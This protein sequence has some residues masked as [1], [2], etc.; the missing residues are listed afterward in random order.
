MPHLFG[1]RICGG[2]S[3]VSSCNTIAIKQTHGRG[4]GDVHFKMTDVMVTQSKADTPQVVKH[5]LSA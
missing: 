3:V 1:A 5:E 4:S 2:R